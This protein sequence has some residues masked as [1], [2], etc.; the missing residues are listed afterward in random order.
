L[1]YLLTEAHKATVHG[2][3]ISQNFISGSPDM[4]QG[5]CLAFGE[6]SKN[7]VSAGDFEERSFVGLY[8]LKNPAGAKFSKI[9][10]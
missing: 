2:G 3:K 1:D 9:S 6:G 8:S 7:W 4:H 5:Q 10:S